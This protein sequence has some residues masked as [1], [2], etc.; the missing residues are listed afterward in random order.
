[1]VAS[2]VLDAR[3]HG[4]LLELREYAD[5]RADP[6]SAL[7]WRAYTASMELYT[8]FATYHAVRTL[9]EQE[10]IRL[11]RVSQAGSEHE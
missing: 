8:Q 10:W 6:E 3:N 1:M 2:D 7:G 9:L 4:V 5:G 11:A